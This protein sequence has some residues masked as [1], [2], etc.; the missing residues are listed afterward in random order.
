[1]AGLPLLKL[2]SLLIKTIS[3]PLGTRLK[4]EA[5]RFPTF[6][7]ASV[8]IGQTS[9]YLQSRVNVLASGY[10]FLGV[11]PLPVDEAM[12]VGVSYLA[13]GIII[14]LGAT[15][16]I[17]EY[18]R[19]EAKNKIKA[20]KAAASEAENNANLEARFT[21]IEQKINDILVSLPTMQQVR[22][23]QLCTAT[24]KYTVGF[25]TEDIPPTLTLH[26]RRN[27]LQ[28]E[29]I[30]SHSSKKQQ[31]QQQQHR[32]LMAMFPLWRRMRR[33]CLITH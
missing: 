26:F 33:R 20:E 7:A 17:I 25:Y 2:S 6:Y 10:K 21:V 29:P 30:D 16:I 18:S 14:F 15:I 8:K 1:M 22:A 19:N 4:F 9:H 28:Q 11:K 27:L 5:S 24:A 32:L 23:S 12:E 31:Q 3:K 13:D